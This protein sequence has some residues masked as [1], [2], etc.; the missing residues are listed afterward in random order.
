[1]V[2]SVTCVIV[3][4]YLILRPMLGYTNDQQLHHYCHLMNPARNLSRQYTR[5]PRVSVHKT[6]KGEGKLREGKVKMLDYY[7][8][9]RMLIFLS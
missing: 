3:S 5:C 7:C 2:F 8:R 6:T 1:M 9:A 4:F